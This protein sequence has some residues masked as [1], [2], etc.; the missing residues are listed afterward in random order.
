[1]TH[2][3]L[4]M[5]FYMAGKKKEEPVSNSDPVFNFNQI[6]SNRWTGLGP[7]QQPSAGTG[8]YITNTAS[9]WVGGTNIL[10]NQYASQQQQLNN[11]VMVRG[12]MI[13]TG[14]GQVAVRERT[15][16]IDPTFSLE[17]I[18]EAQEFIQKLNADRQQLPAH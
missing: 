1:M 17:E 11:A 12:V 10:G 8:V 6:D 15:K 3:V 7:V 13:Y 2:P 18:E 9:P 4:T 14:D 5:P 16:M